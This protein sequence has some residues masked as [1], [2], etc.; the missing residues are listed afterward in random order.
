V[1]ASGPVHLGLVAAK[2]Q[3]RVGRVSRVSSATPAR[4]RR[5]VAEDVDLM[6]PVLIASNSLPTAQWQSERLISL[7]LELYRTGIATEQWV[8]KVADRFERAD[9]RG[10]VDTAGRGNVEAQ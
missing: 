2:P 7:L 5:F 8:L 9:R 1:I 4:L 3:R 6:V 10:F